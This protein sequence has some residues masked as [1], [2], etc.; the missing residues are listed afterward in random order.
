MGLLTFSINLTLDGCAD[1][2]EGIADDLRTSVQ[3]LK[4]ATRDGVLLG[5]TRWLEL[6]SAKSL[7]CGAVAM[8]CRRAR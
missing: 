4:D 5:S 3:K 2:Q 7:S 6:I 1:L 8:H